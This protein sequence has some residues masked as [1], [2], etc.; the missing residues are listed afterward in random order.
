MAYHYSVQNGFVRPTDQQIEA[1]SRNAFYEM[2]EDH[3]G[4]IT[5]QEFMNYAL[6][7]K[8]QPEY[9]YGPS[10]NSPFKQT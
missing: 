9:S 6:K 5:K 10:F 1:F 4:V 8:K 2:D 7:N 3:D